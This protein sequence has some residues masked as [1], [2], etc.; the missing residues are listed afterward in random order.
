VRA[1]VIMSTEADGVTRFKT[2]IGLC[3][4]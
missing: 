1:R 2:T 3:H 4:F